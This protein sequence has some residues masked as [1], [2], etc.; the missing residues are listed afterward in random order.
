MGAE[1]SAIE[2]KTYLLEV[3]LEEVPARMAPTSAQALTAALA[4]E[5]EALRLVPEATATFFTPRRFI[6]RL[7]GLP[8][9]QED[10]VVEK[11][12]PAKAFA[13]DAQGHPTKAAMGFARGQGIEVN[14]LEFTVVDGQEY[15]LAR[16]AE[17]GQ[18]TAT[19]LP[20][21]LEKCLAGMRFPKSMRWGSQKAAFV[22][23][24]HWLLSL[25]GDDVVPFSYAG[26]DA[27]RTTFGHR[28]MGARGPLQVANP[29]V[30]EKVLAENFVVISPVRRREQILGGIEAIEA[31][32][33]LTVIRDEELLEEVTNLVEYPVPSEGSFDEK[34]LTMPAEVL[35][36]SMKYHQ[37]FFAVYDGERLANRFVVINNTQARDA[38]LVV[39]GNVRVLT[40]RLEDAFFF[41]KEDGKRALADYLDPLGGQTFLKGLGSMRD[42]GERVSQLAQRIA[43]LLFDD[44]TVS[45]DAARAGLLSKADLATQMVF[46]FTELQGVMGREYARRSGESDAVATAIFEHY[47]PRFSGDDL[48][49]SKAGAA[50]ALA[51][52]LDTVVGCFQLK[53][54]PT[55]TK[56]PYALRRAVLAVV[57]MLAERRVT[58]PLPVFVN[59][60][61]DNF[62]D[63]VDGDRDALLA[64]VMDFIA[65][66]LR[67]WLAESHATE[68]VDACMASGFEIPFDVQEKCGAVAGL[69]GRPDYEDLV[70]GFKRVINITRKAADN[71]AAFDE[72]GLVE[73]AERELWAA[74]TTL[75][76]SADDLL[77]QRR[78]D[79]VMAQLVG[80]K[81]AIDRYFDDVLVM[82]DDEAVR[83]NRLAM[84]SAIGHF[85][86]GLADF[87]KILA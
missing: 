26:I 83:N 72:T 24:L 42:K 53:L 50:L 14:E 57:R 33:G 61:I 69:R 44:A 81:P 34:F 79:A 87:T 43:H 41:F 74:F 20:P 66:R 12:G 77:A 71:P 19:L 80:L 68:V 67:N 60:A 78:F 30:F 56:D 64:Q 84:L 17:T 22:R 63:T 47:L 82:C 40:A 49:A 25:F 38:S 21:V 31:R 15:I 1:M 35:I 45:A 23:P 6:V 73:P 46:E 32:T 86:L 59:A 37:K 28:F 3:G 11:R 7:E 65:G 70:Q 2:R 5:L 58:T 62:G 54:I 29:D 48:P 55:A 13:F 4:R 39:R 51:D 52:R 75:R 36:T 9:K 16:K 76:L 10:I 18:E 27:G 85:F 8:V